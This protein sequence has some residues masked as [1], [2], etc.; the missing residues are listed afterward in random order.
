MGFATFQDV[1]DR[2]Y[3]TLS[4]EER[5][6]VETRLGDAEGKIRIRIPDLDARIVA[7]PTLADVVARVCA[8]AVIRL[9]INPEGYQEETDGNYS[10]SRFES[11]SEG[12]LTI[13]D[14][15]WRDLGI[16]SKFAVIHS[17]W[18]IPGEF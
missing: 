1:E 4:E 3:R 2:F 12:R 6:L 11:L 10:Y 15:E 17:Y 16:R 9:I 5:V 7:N 13:S 18:Q 8:D 14:E